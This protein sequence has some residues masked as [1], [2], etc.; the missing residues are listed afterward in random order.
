[1]TFAQKKSSKLLLNAINFKDRTF[2]DTFL[3]DTLS[4]TLYTFL[5]HLH[6]YEKNPTLLVYSILLFYQNLYKFLPC[7]FISSW[8]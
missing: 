6:T 2:F 7:S 8:S 1:M 3:K 4:H 5:I